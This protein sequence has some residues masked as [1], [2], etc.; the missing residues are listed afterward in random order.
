MGET[1]AI[2]KKDTIWEDMEQMRDRVMRRA[3]DLFLGDGCRL[4]KDIEDWFNAER[5][6]VWKPAIELTEKDGEFKLKIA[7]PGVDPK[8]LDIEVT[9][10]DLLVKAETRHEQKEEKGQFYACELETG[11]L[12]RAVHFPKKIDPEK[13]KAEFK[14]GILTITAAIAAESAAKKIAITAT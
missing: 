2:R 6:L 1:I 12:F 4:G 7:V 14:N 11:N 5:E 10:E 13:I 9:A 8:D 3:Y